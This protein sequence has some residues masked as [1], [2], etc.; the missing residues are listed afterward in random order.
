MVITASPQKLAPSRIQRPT[1][2]TVSALPGP[3][4]VIALPTV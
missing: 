3:T 2:S 4:V 1:P